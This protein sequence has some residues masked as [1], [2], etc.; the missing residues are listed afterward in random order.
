[1]KKKLAL[2]FSM[3]KFILITTVFCVISNISIAATEAD[4]EAAASS[5]SHRVKSTISKSRRDTE[6]RMASFVDKA[7]Q[8]GKTGDTSGLMAVCASV[9]EFLA[10]L[11]TEELREI[12]AT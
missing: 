10:S 2:E 9:G 11:T 6:E 7:T 5:A 8:S 3:S 1:M 4:T 12:T